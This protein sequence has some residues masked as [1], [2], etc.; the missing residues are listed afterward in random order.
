MNIKTISN[1][2]DMSYDFY[3]K[4]NMHMIEWKLKDMNSK[5]KNL[6]NEINET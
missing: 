1:K 5:N 4:H 2:M 3:N 6:V